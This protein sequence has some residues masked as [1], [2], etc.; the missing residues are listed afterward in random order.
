[1][2]IS[3]L[4]V[5]TPHFPLLRNTSQN[6]SM[7]VTLRINE[8]LEVLAWYNKHNLYTKSMQKKWVKSN[9][10]WCSWADVL[11][12]ALHQVNVF[13]KK[14]SWCIHLVPHV[15]AAPSD[16]H[17][18]HKHQSGLLADW[19]LWA[20]RPRFQ[21]HEDWHQG[22]EWRGLPVQ[23]G[24]A[25]GHGKWEQAVDALHRG[26]DPARSDRLQSF[27]SRSCQKNVDKKK[28]TQL[29]LFLAGNDVGRSSYG[30]LQVKQVFDFA[31]MVLSHG[32]SP[33]ARAYPNK[34]Y[35]RLPFHFVSIRADLRFSLFLYWSYLFWNST[36]G[37]IIRVSP[38]VLA[39]RDWTVKKWGTKQNTKLESHGTFWLY[40][41][42][43]ADFRSSKCLSSSDCFDRRSRVLRTGPG[44]ADAGFHGGAER[45]HLSPERRLP[46]V[47]SSLPPKPPAS[48]VVIFCV[49]TLL[50]W[51]WHC[52][53]EGF[54][55][56]PFW[57]FSVSLQS[58]GSRA[59]SAISHA[60]D[61]MLRVLHLLQPLLNL[62]SP[63]LGVRVSIQQ[64]YPPPPP[65]PGLRSLSHSDGCWPQGCTSNRLHPQHSSGL[66]LFP[67]L[68]E[69]SCVFN[70]VCRLSPRE[71]KWPVCIILVAYFTSFFRFRWLFQKV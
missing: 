64:R 70:T 56:F 32:V 15:Q 68:Q 71:Q 6:T 61:H 40:L 3:F 7:F 39:Y 62:H 52:E 22:E 65:H 69:K 59:F 43:G 63:P 47:F 18:A 12:H 26:S 31:Y 4:Q 5:D 57:T 58:W 24:D 50:F 1:M 55:G 33:L 54:F 19:V 11:G 37:R 49:L 41:V 10:T 27:V 60:F 66:F 34:E 17:T 13:Y 9:L 36:L 28:Q 35:D 14:C 42:P 23:G 16:R 29:D 45:R 20:V 48:L 30:I 21:L 8:L 46:L 25:Q 38:D 53:A 44:K 2:A 67:S 51:K